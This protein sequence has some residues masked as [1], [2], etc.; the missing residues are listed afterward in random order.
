MKENFI[1]GHRE[2]FISLSRN[3][4]CLGIVLLFLNKLTSIVI[5]KYLNIT[6]LIIL[7]FFSGVFWWFFYIKKDEEKFKEKLDSWFKYLFLAGLLIIALNQFFKIELISS[8]NL[9]LVLFTIGFG[10]FTFYFNG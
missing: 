1:D 4:F 9:Y 7:T 2:F 10:F 6:L 3:L 8:L 5:S